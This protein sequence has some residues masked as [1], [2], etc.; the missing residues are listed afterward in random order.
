VAAGQ[1]QLAQQPFAGLDFG[2][3][4]DGAD[5]GAPV[6]SGVAWLG[7][8]FA[9]PPLRTVANDADAIARPNPRRQ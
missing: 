2:A 4:A 1:L 8:V 3:D 6:L 5:D 7:V 9:A